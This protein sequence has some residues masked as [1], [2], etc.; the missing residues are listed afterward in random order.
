MK[1]EAHHEL[2][3]ERAVGAAGRK[4]RSDA[5]TLARNAT[6]GESSHPAAQQRAQGIKLKAGAALSSF[7]AQCWPLRF[8]E[9][10]YGECAPNLERPS[11]LAYTQV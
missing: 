8:T 6:G 1:M 11:P 10:I 3:L 4:H 9:L 7:G 5:P 2:E